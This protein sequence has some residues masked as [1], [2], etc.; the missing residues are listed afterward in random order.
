MSLNMVQ[1]DLTDT[2]CSILYRVDL[3][4]RSTPGPYCNFLTHMLSSGKKHGF[5][6]RYSPDMPL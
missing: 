2:S 4:G 3:D 5:G 6:C 1:F